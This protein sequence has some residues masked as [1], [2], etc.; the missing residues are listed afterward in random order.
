[1]HNAPLH[2]AGLVMGMANTV[3]HRRQGYVRPRPFSASDIERTLDHAFEVV[4]RWEAHGDIEWTDKR[5][6]EC[7][8]G[9]DLTT[10]A[11]TIARGARSYGAV[12]FV[13]NRDQAPDSLYIELGKRLGR[14][15]D[16]DALTF[17]RATFPNLDEVAGTYDLIVSNATLEHI[18][19]MPSLFHSFARLGSP[20]ARM[21]HHVDA[22]TH[23]RW[24]KEVDPLNVLRYSDFIYNRLLRFPGAPNRLRASDYEQAAVQAGWRVVATVPAIL[25]RNEYVHRARLARRFR[26]YDR[27][28]LLAFT[29]VADRLDT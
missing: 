18:E 21:V 29:L 6:L 14:R 5:V 19:E 20:S 26:E 3:R 28:E 2:V 22:Q 16:A 11:L 10:G 8:P 23:M 17:T 4:D 13:D 9:S 12:D 15:V 27:L 1:M 7:G 25:V 24:L